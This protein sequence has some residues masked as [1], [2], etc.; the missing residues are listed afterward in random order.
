MVRVFS[1]ALH[2]RF[3]TPESILKIKKKLFREILKVSPRLYLI[4][5]DNM[6]EFL[7]QIESRF[8]LTPCKVKLQI[9]FG[10]KRF[11]Y[12]YEQCDTKKGVVLSDGRDKEC[13]Y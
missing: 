9:A 11:R 13:C 8:S 3:R 1:R 4:S 7:C 6:I 10:E 12:L 2:M 5:L